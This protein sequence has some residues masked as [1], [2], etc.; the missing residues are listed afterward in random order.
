MSLTCLCA[1]MSNWTVARQAPLCMG[2]P[3]QEYWSG[4]YFLFQG[5][6]LTQGSNLC[7]LSF[8]HWQAGFFITSAIWEAPQYNP[9]KK[10]RVKLKAEII[11]C[12]RYKF[13]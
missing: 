2:F 10:T 13:H 5:I 1:V 11:K 8:L 12:S 9:E 3:R 7:L 4:C 6:L